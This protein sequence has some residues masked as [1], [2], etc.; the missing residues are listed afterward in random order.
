MIN[1]AYEKQDLFLDTVHLV[2]VMDKN[3]AFLHL[4]ESILLLFENILFLTS[5]PKILGSIFE[6]YGSNINRVQMVQIIG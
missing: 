5:L 2:N 3:P 1:V 4:F 6:D